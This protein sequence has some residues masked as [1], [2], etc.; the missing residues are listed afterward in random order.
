MLQPN[1]G[2][3]L[4][5]LRNGLKSEVLPAL[6][7]DGPAG[8]Q[9]RASLYLLTRLERS[10]DLYHQHVYADNKDLER[11]L[12]ATLN[13]LISSG[14]EGNFE[15]LLEELEAANGDG[16]RDLVGLNDPALITATSINLV[17]QDIASRL[18]NELSSTTT[19]TGSTTECAMSLAELYKRMAERDV[20]FVGEQPSKK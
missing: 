19:V 6:E 7:R 20:F 1:P 4:K 11:T 18:Q 14:C 10:W 17:L 8:R 2:M 12:R 5:T 3:L 9:L 16:A 15:L 13:K